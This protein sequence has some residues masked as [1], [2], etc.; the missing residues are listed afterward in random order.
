MSESTRRIWETR[1]L[2]IRLAMRKFYANTLKPW[3]G[4]NDSEL[5]RS[6]FYEL[7]SFDTSILIIRSQLLT[8][9]LMSQKACVINTI[10]LRLLTRTTALLIQSYE[11]AKLWFGIQLCTDESKSWELILL[12]QWKSDIYW[13][14]PNSA[15]LYQILDSLRLALYFLL[16]TLPSHPNVAYNPQTINNSSQV[17]PPAQQTVQIP[18]SVC[19]LF[20]EDATKKDQEHVMAE[21]VKTK[22]PEICTET[23]GNANINFLS[24]RINLGAESSW[25]RIHINTN[26][27]WCF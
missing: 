19:I 26:K 12:P 3:A 7:R 4:L 5:L 15:N 9:I 10:T 27:Y 11:S 25:I 24:L 8:S 17:I 1:Y 18:K 22:F 23:I 16:F 14:A 2:I 21:S 6:F 13:S 20:N